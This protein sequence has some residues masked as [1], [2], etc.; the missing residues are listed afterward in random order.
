MKHKKTLVTSQENK[1]NNRSKKIDIVYVSSR[2]KKIH[3]VC[4]SKSLCHFDIKVHFIIQCFK[5][6]SKSS[7]TIPLSSSI[8]IK[9]NPK[10]LEQLYHH[11]KNINSTSTTITT[12]IVS[13]V[14]P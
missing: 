9:N 14:C 10:Y 7:N 5:I 2:K 12:A 13:L 4:D 3:K 8:A 6:A 1:K 11:I